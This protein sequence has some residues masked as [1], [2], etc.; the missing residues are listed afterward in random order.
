MLLVY[1]VASVRLVVV[2]V[3]GMLNDCRDCRLRS[4]V[5]ECIDTGEGV[6]EKTG[7]DETLVKPVR[8]RK[9]PGFSK[10]CGTSKTCSNS[11]FR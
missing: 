3:L 5:E 11:G 10:P 2:G 1:V 4:G 9:S 8:R 7:V 6:I